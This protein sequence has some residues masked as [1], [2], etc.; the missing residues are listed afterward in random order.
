MFHQVAFLDTHAMFAG[1][2]ATGIDAGHQDFGAGRFRCL[3]LARHRSI[4]HHQRVEVTVAS[5]KDIGDP[6]A[7]AGN[8]GADL[9]EHRTKLAARD[10]AINAIIIRRDAAYGWKRRLAPG[11]EQQALRL[12]GGG[13]QVG[14]VVGVG[15]G[16]DAGKLIVHLRRAAIGL[17]N[18]QRF[19]IS[20]IAGLH[21]IF[22]G[23]E[24]RRVHH[25]QPRRDDASG[26]DGRHAITGIGDG[27]KT[28]QQRAL[29]GGFGQDAHRGFGDDAQKPF[30]TADQPEQII[31]GLLL[32]RPA[33][34][35]HGAVHQHQLNAQQIGAGGAIFQAMH[36][37]GIFRDIAADRAGN[38]AGRIGRVVKAL[39]GNG[40]GDGEIGDTRL[41]H[42]AA[43]VVI[44]AQ[45]AVEARH[46]QHDAIGQRQ[47]PARKRRART[48]RHHLHAV[49]MA[50]G[51]H[52][53]HLFGRAR[54]HHG[55]RALPVHHQPIA[56][57]R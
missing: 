8:D 18:H 16:G 43:I 37:A 21:K 38:L 17:G 20:G 50:P 40:L 51:Q 45:D 44:H 56:A 12:V 19:D 6:K 10:G 52:L 3:G 23:A 1:Q 15:D 11:P 47:R 25:L 48:A 57:I 39:V 22:G 2:H 35:Q 5:V 28:Q 26:D 42:G 7:V 29:G 14:T 33:Q 36:P 32:P 55:Q 46:A 54:Q 13:A 41:H 27:G 30:R 24:G 31:T 34:A 49:G 4:I 9:T 53:A